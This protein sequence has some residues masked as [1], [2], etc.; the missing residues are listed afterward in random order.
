MLA[1]EPQPAGEVEAVMLA[2]VDEAERRLLD[3]DD[4]GMIS[5][6]LDP[7]RNHQGGRAQA[8]FR[9]GDGTSW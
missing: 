9:E 7:K 1:C 3:G 2:L 5:H 8:R 6:R 4:P